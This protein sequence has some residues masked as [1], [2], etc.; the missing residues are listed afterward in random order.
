MAFATHAP[1]LMFSGAAVGY[2]KTTDR[3][4]FTVGIWQPDPKRLGEAQLSGKESDAELV[5]KA[6]QLL[7][8]SVSSLGAWSDGPMAGVRREENDHAHALI[9]ACVKRGLIRQG[10]TKMSFEKRV[11]ALLDFV[12]AQDEP[13]KKALVGAMNKDLGLDLK[14]SSVALQ[15]AQVCEVLQRR[16]YNGRIKNL[17]LTMAKAEGCAIVQDFRPPLVETLMFTGALELRA[18]QLAKDAVWESYARNR[19]IDKTRPATGADMVATGDGKAGGAGMQ[20]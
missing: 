13:T 9:D 14:A 2:T 10:Y 1:R 16:R 5:E 3:K 8:W 17:I 20:A 7:R 19:M 12:D 6:A 4:D 15:G 18:A 11:D